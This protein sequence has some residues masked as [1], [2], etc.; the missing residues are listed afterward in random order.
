MQKTEV[1]C[2][3]C[4]ANITTT[5]KMPA[6]RLR[7]S[8]EKLPHTSRAIYAILVHPPIDCDHHFCNLACLS[9]W[10]VEGNSGQRANRTS[11]NRD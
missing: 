10:L 1:T 5:D 9:S 8:A 2:D 11:K 7:L 6:F 3:Y 4:N